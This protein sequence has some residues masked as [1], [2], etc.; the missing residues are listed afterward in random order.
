MVGSRTDRRY[1]LT[2]PLGK[3]T[4]RNICYSAMQF[5]L[6]CQK[7][8]H[9]RS[10]GI[11]INRQRDGRPRF[12]GPIYSSDGREMLDSGSQ[13]LFP[14]KVGNNRIISKRNIFLHTLTPRDLGRNC[15]V[16]FA[17][18]YRGAGMPLRIQFCL[19]CGKPNNVPISSTY[20]FS[21]TF[22]FKYRILIEILYLKIPPPR[23]S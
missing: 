21:N 15:L 4:V 2:N 20:K 3:L 9:Y 6:D 7:Y 13:M 19:D 18:K 8:F 1:Y 10:A 14:T 5:L 12:Q 22:K 23:R 11:W 16:R 17:M